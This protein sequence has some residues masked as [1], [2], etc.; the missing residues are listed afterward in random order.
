M[1][2]YAVLA[3]IPLLLAL[4]A[5]GGSSSTLP[6]NVNN[7]SSAAQ[8]AAG[9]YVVGF[10]PGVST[11][12]VQAVTGGLANR[13]DH[14]YHTSFNGFAGPLTGAERSSLANDPRVA[15]VEPDIELTAF[16]KPPWAGGGGGGDST[17]PPQETPWGVNRIDAALSNGTGAGVR[18][19]VIDTGIDL[20]HPDLAGNVEDGFNALHPGDPAEDDNGHGTHVAGTIAAV[21]NAIGVVGV[22]P[23]ATVVAVKVLDRRG[24]GWVSDIVNGIDWVTTQNTDGNANNDIQVANMSLGGRGT[25]SAMSIAISTAT[26]SG[27]IFAVAAGNDSANAANYIPAS[28]PFVICVSALDQNDNFAYFSN[29]GAVVDV[30]APGVNIPS[31]YKKGGYKTLSGTSMASPHVAGSIA[32]WLDDG[33]HATDFASVKAGIINNGWPGPWDGDPDNYPEPLVNAEPL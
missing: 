22:A 32:L 19:A 14:S 8:A 1:T 30:I 31:L 12:Q 18:V 13:P 17:P 21:D 24:R 9:R 23:N 28:Y 6:G 15:F 33:D 20:T 7:T 29:Y 16:P 3:L 26:N 4:A 10:A 11:S 5:C 27:C 25:S 2:K